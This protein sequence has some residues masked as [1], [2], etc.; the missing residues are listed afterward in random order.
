MNESLRP[1]R[2]LLRSAGYIIAEVLAVGGGITALVE[3]ANNL[4]VEAIITAGTLAVG[5]FLADKIAESIT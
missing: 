4:G 5:G 2:R 1:D 3:V